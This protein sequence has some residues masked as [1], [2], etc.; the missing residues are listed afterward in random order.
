MARL[1]AF[2]LAL[3]TA[4]PTSLEMSC[5]SC[6]L[7]ARYSSRSAPRLRV[8]DTPGRHSWAEAD[9]DAYART[10]VERYSRRAV[11]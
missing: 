4:F 6:T 2:A 1:K 5:S 10:A 9:A 11:A 3:P 7:P 8:H